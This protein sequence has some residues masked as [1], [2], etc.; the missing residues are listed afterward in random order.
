MPQPQSSRAAEGRVF[1]AE[2]ADTTEG[3]TPVQI[4][5]KLQ[6]LLRRPQLAAGFFP[7]NVP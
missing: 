7:L 6:D 1:N 3:S 4:L 2:A 5:H